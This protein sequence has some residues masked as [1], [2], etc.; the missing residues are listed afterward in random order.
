MKKKLIYLIGIMLSMS[1]LFGCDKNTEPTVPIES[2]VNEVKPVVSDSPTELE[3]DNEESN[4]DTCELEDG[5]YLADFNTDSSMFHVNE[6]CDGKGELTVS[7]GKMTIHI[8]LP[9][10][11]I[12]NLYSGLAEDAAKDGATLLEPTVDTIDYNDGTT[13]EVHGFDIPVPYLDDEFDVALIGTK[14]KWYDHKVSVSNPVK[15]D[16]S[17]SDDSDKE[18]ND[19]SA[20]KGDY[21]IEVT[22]EGGTGKATIS[23]PSAAKKTDDGYVLIVEWSSPNYDYMIVDGVKYLPVNEE[24][25]SVFEIPVKS[26]EGSVDVIADTVAMSKPH[27][28]EYKIIFNS[29][30]L[31]EAK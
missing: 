31:K 4:T 13:E 16:A 2:I 27:E 28:I 10:K 1:L 25:N 12:L 11:S 8:S 26:L 18:S 21:T 14:G 7:D 29:D 6:M 23:S 5:V 17:N 22:L 19:G 9:S 30:S 15:K 24:G 3:G 20:L